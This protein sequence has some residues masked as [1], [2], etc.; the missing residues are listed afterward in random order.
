M[1]TYK[2]IHGKTVQH[3]ASDPDDGAYEGQLWFNTTSSDYKTITRV[4]GSWSAGGALNTARKELGGC[5]TQTA[6]M[7]FGGGGP[8]DETEIYDGSSWTEVGDLNTARKKIE[9]MG[10][11]TAALA[12]GGAEDTDDAE[13]WDGS[14]W[15]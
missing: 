2:A 1:T 4:A 5:G 7:A 12:C 6:G 9:G 8:D 15:T 13:L 10:T 11:T 14:S 3:L